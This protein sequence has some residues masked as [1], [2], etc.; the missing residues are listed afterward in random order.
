MKAKDVMTKKLVVFGP[1]DSI[2]KVIRMLSHKHISGAPVVDKNRRVVGVVSNSDVIKVLDIYAPKIH[3]TSAPEFLFLLAGLKIKKN[4]DELE[5]EIN[6]AIK[7]KVKNFMTKNPIII[8]E[9]TDL[10]NVARLMDKYDVNRLLVV[11]NKKRLVGI[12]TRDDLIT[13]LSRFVNNFKIKK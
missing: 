10:K 2:F 7:I 5:K 4:L 8:F 11:N 3:L 6:S 9:D 12:L 1:D 13:T